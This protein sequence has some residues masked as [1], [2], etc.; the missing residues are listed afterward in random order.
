MR[1]REERRSTKLDEQAHRSTRR[2][3]GVRAAA[4]RHNQ[5]ELETHDGTA[6][7]Q[8][9]RSEVGRASEMAG[10]NEMDRQSNP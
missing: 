6:E 8:S 3:K 2:E 7:C 5:G 4:D 1:Y 10:E 9:L